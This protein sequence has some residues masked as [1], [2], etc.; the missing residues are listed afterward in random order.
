MIMSALLE[1]RQINKSFGSNL[2]LQD[3][4]LELHENEALALLGEN[5]AGKSTL[6]KILGGIYSRDS[7]EIFING[8][9]VSINSVGEARSHGISI[10][11]QELMLAEDLS[12][13][14]N[15]FMGNEL[16]GPGGFLSLKIQNQAA[17]EKLDRYNL[18][19][20][21]DETLGR[22]TIAQRQM[23]EIVRAVSFGARIIVMDEPTSSLSSHEVNILFDMIRRLKEEGVGIIYI[24]HR[25]DELYEITD[26]VAVLRD[27]TNAGTV[28]TK[29]TKRQQLV[30]M[31]VG[32]ELSSYYIKDNLPSQQV[33]FKAEHLADGRRVRD[34]SFEL[35]QGEILGLSGLV[36]AGR[37]EA[38]ECIFGLRKKTGGA[39]WLDGKQVEFHTPQEAM[40]AG[41]GFVPEDRKGSGLFLKQNVQFNTT[42]TI[43]DRL[44]HRL[45]YDGRQEIDI[46]DGMIRDI[47]VK[48]TG[49]DQT[50]GNLSG[51]NQ[52]KV[53]I[54]KWLLSAKRILILDEPTRGVD[55]KTKAEIYSLM[56]E[57][58][59]KGLSIIVVSSELPELIN[60]C[61]RIVTLCR[62]CSTGV[63]SRDEFSQER[64]MTLATTEEETV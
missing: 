24:S 52:Q 42:I 19:L 38:M 36:G 64:I 59:K 35:R 2:V 37:S 3:V 6:I 33:V 44:F 48:V 25:L 43:L 27:G 50:V 28:V 60:M 23:V 49:R 34:V 31:M 10:I 22:L 17:Q 29:E 58:A 51:G 40:K 1:M 57:L 16:C 54:G 7:G 26:K 45:K 20:R 46:V 5:G 63:L 13:G 61:D 47:Q 18:D 14:E 62:G 30:A 55:V 41:I 4:S 53:L 8:R 12:I 39:V 56:N 9:P 32:R 11:H 15:I 21:A